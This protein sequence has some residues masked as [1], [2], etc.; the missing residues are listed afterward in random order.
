MFARLIYFIL[1]LDSLTLV[2]LGSSVP[3]YPPPPL[4]P[5]VCKRREIHGM[6]GVEVSQGGYSSVRELVRILNAPNLLFQS[7]VWLLL[8]LFRGASSLQLWQ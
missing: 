1:E 7:P 2:V 5:P 6:I 4:I 3:L 8:F